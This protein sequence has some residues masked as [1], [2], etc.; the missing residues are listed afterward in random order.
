MTIGFLGSTKHKIVHPN[1]NMVDVESAFTDGFI[2]QI[3]FE[4]QPDG[5]YGHLNQDASGLRAQNVNLICATGGL[6]SARSAAVAAQGQIPVLVIVGK[7]P[8]ATGNIYD[9]LSGN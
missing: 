7:M 6:P 8:T 5:K 2:G 4:N 1:G 9:D 3:D